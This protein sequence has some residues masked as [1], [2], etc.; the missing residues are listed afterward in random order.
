MEEMRRAAPKEFSPA[1]TPK[2]EL[3]L[4]VEGD[5]FHWEAR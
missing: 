2:K 4:I 1:A 3:K 5:A